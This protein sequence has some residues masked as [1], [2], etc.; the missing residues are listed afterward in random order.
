MI[1]QGE[2]TISRNKSPHT[3]RQII[4]NAFFQRPT[5]TIT[6]SRREGMA[7][8]FRAC[9]DSP[10]FNLLCGAFIRSIARHHYLRL[11]WKHLPLHSSLMVLVIAKVALTSHPPKERLS[12]WQTF[13]M[14]PTTQETLCSSGLHIWYIHIFKLQLSLSLI[15][16]IQ[17]VRCSRV[18]RVSYVSHVNLLGASDIKRSISREYR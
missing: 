8:I 18:G 12:S 3:H 9:S 16:T 17:W 14:R 10:C 15:S 13:G 7:E 5:I 1:R 11:A 4:H 6:M 2:A